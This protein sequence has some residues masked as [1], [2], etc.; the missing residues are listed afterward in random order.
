M[1]R[2]K[3]F[4]LIELLVVIAIIAILAAILFP[5]FAQ[6]K[7]AAKKTVAISNAKQIALALNMYAG[8]ADDVIMPS[9]T[10]N[11]PGINGATNTNKPFDC[12]MQPYVKSYDFWHTPGD[13]RPLE[14]G[15]QSDNDL[16]DGSLKGKPILRSFAYIGH[17]TTDQDGGYMD[18]N[19]GIGPIGWDVP[20][21]PVRTMTE[22]SE[23]SNT[24]AFAEVWAPGGGPR[25]GVRDGGTLINCDTWKFAG[26]VTPS[27]DPQDALPDGAKEG[28]GCRGGDGE[29]ADGRLWRLRGLRSRGRQREGVHLA[30]DP[31][32]RPV[33][34]Q[35]PEAEHGGVALRGSLPPGDRRAACN[36]LLGPG[37]PGAGRLSARFQ[38]R[39]RNAVHGNGPVFDWGGPGSVGREQE[40][41]RGLA[42]SRREV[43]LCLA[44]D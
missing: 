43:R 35:G 31:E 34:V 8:D 22:F 20:T 40:R 14:G 11:T 3:A 12:M 21:Y 44:R 42:P 32:E 33:H 1:R 41:Q 6:A 37:R 16:W 10:Y 24:L 28:R 4:T 19:T 36:G 26:R 25:V 7:L 27:T 2:R 13:Q 30:P 18:R 17:V 29:Q 9:Y 38:E 5:V 15:G 23:P 39:H